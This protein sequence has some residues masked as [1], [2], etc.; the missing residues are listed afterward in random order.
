MARSKGVRWGLGSG[1][2]RGVEPVAETWEEIHEQDATDGKRFEHQEAV[3]SMM[4]GQALTWESRQLLGNAGAEEGE[5]VVG[6]ARYFKIGNHR[7]MGHLRVGREEE[8][9]S[10]LRPELTASILSHQISALAL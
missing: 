6:H 7:R 10:S 8:G 9:T 3:R 5:I 1:A 2:S 4:A